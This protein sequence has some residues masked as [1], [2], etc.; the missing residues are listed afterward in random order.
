MQRFIQEAKAASGLNHPNILTIHEIEQIDSTHLIATEF[1]DG[2]TL[3]QQLNFGPM[4]TAEALDISVQLASA[5]SAA[6]AAGII[7][8]DIKP[9][10]VM[11]RRDGIVKVLDFGLAKLSGKVDPE[12]K[13]DAEAATKV[14]VQTEPGVVMGTV[15]YMS[16]EQARG[17]DVDARTDVFS[18]GVVIYE[19]LSG[20]VPFN[21][22]TR[23]DVIAAILKTEPSPLATDVDQVPR[24]LERIVRKCLQKDR[25][26]RYSSARELQVDLKNLRREL[27]V[28][29]AV[30]TVRSHERQPTLLVSRR[31]LV[32]SAL[33][34]LVMT[35]FGYLWLFRGAT[36]TISPGIK[37]LAVLPLENLS[38][39][40]A[41]EYF[42]DGMTEAL[43]SN[44]AQ[45]RALERVISR[46]SVMRYKGS[47]KSLPE[48]AAE[49]NV[50]AVVEGTVQRSGERVLVTAKLIPA[51]TDSPLWTREYNR[52]L[53]D[54]LKLQSEVARAVA[55]EI[56]IQV[57]PE[58]QTRL[59]AA[60][61]INPQAHEAYLRG[62]YHLRT[63]EEDLRQAIEQFGRTI[64]LA[65]DYAP[66]HAAL[67]R[68]WMM[69]GIWGA[70]N[71]K[72]AAT[73]AR[74]AALKAV[75]LDPQ[76]P[77]AHVELSDVKFYD[78]DWEGAEQEIRR[79]TELDPNS[80]RAH[81]A[82]ADM[83]M[84]LERHDQAITEIQRAE[85]LDPLS[86]FVQSRYGRVLYRARKYEEAVPYLYRAIELDP[87]PGN[88]MPYWILG[89]IY[90][91]MG[92]YDEAIANY[93]KFQSQIGHDPV[94]SPAGIARAY[95]RM[96]KLNEAR[97]ILAE[98]K[99][100]TDPSRFSTGPVAQAYTA[101]GDKDEAFKVL[102]RLVE[103]RIN[104]ATHIKADP[105]LDSLH[106]DARWKELLRRMNLN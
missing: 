93:K 65:P 42:A 57:T 98:M 79:A 60:R 27:E 95:A 81:Q 75:A 19:M 22:E 80:A 91:E 78:F 83:L 94:G 69:R 16:P 51:A 8:R 50:D 82:Y 88:A 64:Q 11:L 77:E 28:G 15:A 72:E 31:L 44:L 52:D 34:I 101:L 104:L 39:D 99:A 66:A 105:G 74:D 18:L 67:A 106:T 7:H 32:V 29:S 55:D 13:V 33:V 12:Q 70:I 90:V 84:A 14:L 73:F 87:E 1:I 68:A 21:G 10:N 58:E 36:R 63:N 92:R 62:L 96:G 5:L 47:R 9:E 61:N 43:I 103:E 30:P 76:L 38:G 20:R 41:Q 40:P 56:R 24:E 45:I 71:R 54:V 25:E 48:I 49:L 53:S 46:T 3:R 4:E 97:R 6:H 100:T 59:A 89:D 17:K 35:S 23:S 85:Q 2:E 37:S 86:S 26:R 102:F